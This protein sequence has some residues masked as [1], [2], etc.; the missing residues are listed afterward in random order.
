[1]TEEE[2]VVARHVI[3]FLMNWGPHRHLCQAYDAL[4][5]KVTALTNWQ[6]NDSV[7]TLYDLLRND[8]LK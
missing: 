8:K 5:S 6:R 4:F 1:L 2:A 7:R 3:E